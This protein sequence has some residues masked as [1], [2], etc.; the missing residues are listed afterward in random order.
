MRPEYTPKFIE[1]FW[2]KVQKGSP[3]D[4]W[5]W[6]AGGGRYGHLR[7]RVGQEILSNSAHRIAW[8]LT[9]GAIPPDLEVCHNCPTG[10]NPY[11]VNPAHLWLGTHADNIVDKVSK[12]RQAKGST[13]GS[14]THPERLASGNRNGMRTKPDTRLHGERNGLAKLTEQSVRDIRAR[15]ASGE[16]SIRVL[17]QAFGVTPDT[18]YLVVR[19]KTWQHIE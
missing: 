12:G 19:R 3:A 6:Q 9:H 15:H 14:R 11:C 18:V 1:R 17:A 5:I 4:C 13:H 7:Y 10:D 8:E 16:C 2:S